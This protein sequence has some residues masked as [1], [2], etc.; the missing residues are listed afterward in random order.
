MA[1]ARTAVHGRADGDGDSR[2]WRRRRR[3]DSNAGGNNGGACGNATTGARGDAATCA[4]GNATSRACR[5]AAT[6]ARRDA[7]ARTRA[8]DCD[9]DADEADIHTCG[10]GNANG[11]TGHT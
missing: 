5:D 7:A 9:S 2:L 6:C 3:G 8:G 1:D 4:C 11:R 10:N